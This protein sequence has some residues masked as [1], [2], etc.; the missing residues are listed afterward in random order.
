M[1]GTIPTPDPTP[2]EQQDEPTTK[3]AT[4]PEAVK[5]KAPGFRK[6]P[7]PPTTPSSSPDEGLD[8][9][10][11]SDAGFPEMSDELPGPEPTKSGS[12]RTSSRA[13]KKALR[14]AVRVAFGGATTAAHELLVKDEYGKHAQLYLAD[15]QDLEAVSEP[16]GNLLARRMGDSPVSAD[17]ADAI[18]LLIAL[19]GYALKQLGRI[20]YARALRDSNAAVNGF[21][22]NLDLEEP[23]A[24]PEPA[25]GPA[26]G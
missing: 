13:E 1:T 21:Q 17:A 20:R 2:E 26:A 10:S 4:A 3:E 11:G 18:A 14:D 25:Y 5:V 12:S 8:A 22:P 19:A 16:G 24:D 7:R 15:D 9:S 23:L 6:V